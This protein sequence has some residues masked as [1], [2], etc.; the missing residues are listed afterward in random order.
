VLTLEL[1]REPSLAEVAVAAE[2]SPAQVE[3]AL[4]VPAGFVSID[5]ANADNREPATEIVDAQASQAYERVD[6]LLTD[7]HLDDLLDE[8]PAQQRQVIALR[9]GFTGEERTTEQTAADLDISPEQVQALER[10]ALQ[11]LRELS[12]LA[13]LE[14]AA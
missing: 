11:R 4:N 12:S 1:E 3:Q 6:E 9:Y 2:L 10:T 7:T 5:G 14:Q 13:D 8:L